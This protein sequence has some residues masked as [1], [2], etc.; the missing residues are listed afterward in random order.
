[1]TWIIHKGDRTT[2]YNLNDASIVSLEENFIILDCGEREI[3]LKYENEQ[4]AK[5][6]FSYLKESIKRGDKLLNI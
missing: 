5:Q 6:A 2:L 4:E 3:P 1:M